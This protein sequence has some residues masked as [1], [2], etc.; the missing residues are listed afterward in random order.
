[1]N[2]IERAFEKATKVTIQNDNIK[3]IEDGTYID[4]F[5]VSLTATELYQ[6][7]FEVLE[8]VNAERKKAGVPALV[9]DPGLLDTAMQRSFET[10]LYW[11]HTRP[12]GLDCFTANNKMRGE[13]IA[14][15]APT[16]ESAMDMWMSRTTRANI[17]S[18]GFTS[19]G[20][21][22]VYA[23]GG[24]YWVQCF[25]TDRGTAASAGNYRNTTNTRTIFVKREEPYSAVQSCG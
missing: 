18:S 12:N 20:V 4:G 23:D 8:L 19:L 16:P 2:V 25:G 1:M 17:L 5:Y 21:G 15:G 22:C 11:S 7:A 14:A 9:M 10:A 13:N 6:N 3:Q 24:Y